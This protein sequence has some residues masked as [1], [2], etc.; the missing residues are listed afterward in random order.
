MCEFRDYKEGETCGCESTC[1]KSE[2]GMEFR[3]YMVVLSL[4][5]VGVMIITI[6]LII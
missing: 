3:D 1:S 5:L 6:L 2:E 4:I